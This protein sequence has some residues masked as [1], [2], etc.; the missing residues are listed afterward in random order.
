MS[1]TARLSL[2][3]QGLD[4][5]DAEARRVLERAK[6]QVGFIPNMYAGMAN[7][8]GLLETYLDGYDR[9]RKH[10]GLT[11][12]EQEVVFLT[13]S[14]LNGCDYC[15]AAHSMIADKMSNVPAPVLTA[16]REGRP[17]P[18]ARLAA[19]AA[20]TEVM[21]HSRGRPTATDLQAFTVAGYSERQA[22]EIVLAMAVKTLSNYSNHLFH[23]EVDTAFSA[24]RLPTAA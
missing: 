3:V 13:V 7:A 22:L 19:L 23:T 15:T 6:A 10:S 1:S 8:P 2:P 9:F 5:A 20:F 14:R 11:P 18:D 17:L 12:P 16:L 4:S 21:F 24:Y